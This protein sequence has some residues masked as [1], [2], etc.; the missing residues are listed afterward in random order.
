MLRLAV[1]IGGTFTD[2]VLQDPQS[3]RV[4]VWKVPTTRAPAL[5]VE[6]T[7]A[8]KVAKSP[9]QDFVRDYKAFAT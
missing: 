8:E 1:D 6:A 2:Y 9:S 3:G 5:G 7:L 4:R